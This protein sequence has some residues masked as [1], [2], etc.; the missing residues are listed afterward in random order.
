M[1]VYWEWSL[2]HLNMCCKTVVQK[3]VLEK[4]LHSL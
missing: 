4:K 3:N 1:Y 2:I